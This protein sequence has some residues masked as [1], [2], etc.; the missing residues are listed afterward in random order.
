[1]P[2]H[3]IQK[4]ILYFRLKRKNRIEPNS[5]RGEDRDCCKWVKMMFDLLAESRKHRM[6]E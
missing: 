6:E 4:L 2:L 5:L 1:M 3:S